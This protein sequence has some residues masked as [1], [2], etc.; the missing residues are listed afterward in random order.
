MT[1]AVDRVQQTAG[2][3]LHRV[4]VY[5]RRAPLMALAVAAASGYVLRSL[6]VMA[7]LGVVAR[8]ALVLVR[9]FI[10]ILGAVNLYEF[11]RTKNDPAVEE[12]TPGEPGRN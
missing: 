12:Y 3:Q 5:T 9:P 1:S 8:L 4:E 11:I 10:F 6:P 2:E 7:L